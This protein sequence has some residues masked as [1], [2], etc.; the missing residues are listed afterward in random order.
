MAIS[1]RFLQDNVN[2]LLKNAIL[3]RSPVTDKAKVILRLSYPPARD[4][5]Y[6]VDGVPA[7]SVAARFGYTYQYY[8]MLCTM[9]RQDRVQFFRESTKLDNKSER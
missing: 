3:K 9:L 4:C 8:R 6:F 5:A 7:R 1:S 2:L